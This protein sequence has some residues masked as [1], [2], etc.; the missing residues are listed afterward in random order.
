MK[1]K[2]LKT[3]IEHHYSTTLSRVRDEQSPWYLYLATAMTVRDQISE[4]WRTT[5]ERRRD[6]GEKRVFYL[7]MEFLLGRALTNALKNL[8][9][10]DA[11]RKAMERYGVTI[12]ELQAQESDAGL[13]NGG[14]GRLAACFLDSCAS[15][16]LPVTGYGLRYEY[17]MFHQSVENGYQVERPDHWL[18]RGYPWEIERSELSRRIKF[19][20]RTETFEDDDGNTCYRWTDTHDVIAVPYDLPIPGYR[21]NVVNTLRLWASQATDQFDLG[22]FNAGSYAESVAQK[23]AAENITMVLYPND[24]SENGKALRLQQQYFLASAS[25]QDIIGQWVK[26]H[27]MDFSG[28][29]DAHCFQL[30]DTHPAI[31]VAELMRILLDVYKLEWDEAWSIVTSTVAY[32]NHTLLPEALETWSVALFRHMLPRLLDIIFEINARFL[33]EVAAAYPG[34]QDIQRTLSIITEDDDPQIRMAHLAVVG[35]FSVNGVAALHSE[36][37]TTQLFREFH[38]LWPW[39][40]NNK[41]NGVSPRRWLAHCNPKLSSLITEAIGDEWQNDLT[42]I[43]DLHRHVDD[44]DFAER[45]LNVK[46]DNKVCLANYLGRKTGVALAPEM[47]VDV[48]VKRIHEYKRQLLNVL[49]VIYQYHKIHQG[50][51]APSAGRFVLIGG[52]A[53]PGYA[54]AKT[55]IKLINN[56]AEAVNN[57][58]AVNDQLR[59]TFVPNY[60][61]TAMEQICP[62]ADL[63]SQIST[64]GKEASG[65]GN[66]KLMMNG[67]VTIG[68]ADGANIEILDRVGEDNFFLFGLSAA[69]V[70]AK[71]C[72]YDPNRIIEE[73]ADFSAVMNLLQS[74]QFNMFEPGIFDCIIR[75]IRD[76]HDPWMIAA[77]FRAFVDAQDDAMAAYMDKPRWARM[78]IVNTAS[79]AH[80]SSDRTIEEYERDIWRTRS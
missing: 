20:G 44:S 32:T 5:R 55:I 34:D 79:S 17:G 47:M 19:F 72:D 4:A 50:E 9:M 66:M 6:D 22:E 70:Q 73:D 80:F 57:D 24:A 43:E 40:F 15:M 18:L 76:P 3:K 63:S 41:T 16:D 38:D 7:S 74:G 64:A 30:N 54:M 2:K 69:E 12:E 13:G 65:T 68:T 39:K 26:H 48:Q 46:Q 77:D 42:H 21:N 14:L 31:T 51:A 10:D 61:V 35:S 8:D 71:R 62:A 59:M 11:A 52:K 78:S 37:I 75:H 23:N 28:F 56:V 49:H 33:S 45:W 36:L 58:P 53:A 29:A 1:A 60:S 25:M 27:G 67:A